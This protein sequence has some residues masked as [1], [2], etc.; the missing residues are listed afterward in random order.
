MAWKK[1]SDGDSPCTYDDCTNPWHA[2]DRSPNAKHGSVRLPFSA[3][4]RRPSTDCCPTH[5][6]IC[7]RLIGEPLL[8]LMTMLRMALLLGND[9]ST[10][11]PACMSA[12]D[13]MR[14]M[15]FSARSTFSGVTSSC[16]ISCV[17]SSARRLAAEILSPTSWLP[18]G[19]STQSLR[20][21]L[22]PTIALYASAMRCKSEMQCAATLPPS[23][24]YTTSMIPPDA[25]PRHDLFSC[26]L[27]TW[28]LWMII[29]LTSIVSIVDADSRSML[30]LVGSSEDTSCLPVQ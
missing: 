6:P 20:P 30:R 1:N 10:M 24:R 7:D 15:V 8:P 26:P 16:P 4:I 17:I 23:C 3:T 27:R 29:L 13:R 25:L 28:P 12:L 14:R 9:C 11:L 19:S 18:L 2:S 22:N 5:A 21:T